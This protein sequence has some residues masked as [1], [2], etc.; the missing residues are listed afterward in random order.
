MMVT[1]NALGYVSAVFLAGLL[2]LAGCSSST[3][4]ETDAQRD[5]SAQLN[6][7]EER[8]EYLENAANHPLGVQSTRSSTGDDPGETM[9]NSSEPTAAGAANVAF[10]QQEY[11][12]QVQSLCAS[13]GV[14]CSR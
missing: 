1:R 14:D 11:E 8:V 2:G 12:R 5:M 6:L 9:T 4:K 7:L 13:K 10:D 3:S